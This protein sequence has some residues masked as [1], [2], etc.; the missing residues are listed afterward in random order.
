MQVVV[1]A[2]GPTLDS[3]ADPRFGRARY[4]ILVNTDTGS[5]SCVDNEINLNA[6][7]GAG[8]QTG[9]KVVELKAQAVVTGHVGPKA[10]AVLNV[11]GISI[12]TGASGT[13][14]QVIE[15]FKSGALKPV[16]SADVEGH[17]A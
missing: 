6:P 4:L 10:F 12:Y 17:W 1:T 8:I 14:S 3:P 16:Q 11:G 9:K 2:Q 15:Q 5:Y 13:V 7:Q